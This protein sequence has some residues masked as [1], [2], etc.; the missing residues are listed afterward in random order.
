MDQNLRVRS[1]SDLI[2]HHYLRS[3]LL[4]VL[5]VE[6]VLVVAYFAVN[7]WSNAESEKTL[8]AE[9][10][11]I[12]PHLA[13][14]EASLLQEGFLRIDRETSL[15]AREHEALVADPGRFIVRGEKPELARAANGS[16]YQTN[17]TEHSGYFASAKTVMD[18]AERNLAEATASLD[19]LYEHAVKDIPNV[20]ASYYNSADNTNRLYPYIPKVWEQ[21]PAELRMADFNFYYL[22]DPSH[23]PL[24]KT[25]WTGAYLDPA[26]Q[27]WMVSCISPVYRRDTLQGVVGLDVTID[28]IVRNLFDQNLPW[29]SAA[30][31]VDDSGMIIAMSSPVE[32]LLGLR[33]LKA[34]VYDAAISTE[35]LKPREFNL[36]SNPDRGIAER[37]RRIIDSGEASTTIRIGG[38]ESF[39][40][41]ERIP[42]TGWRLFLVAQSKDVFQSV[43]GVSHRSRTVGWF[44]VGG[45]LA[46]YIG[47]F[48]YL[49][50]N[51]RR[52]SEGISRPITDLAEATTRLGKGASEVTEDLGP[53]GIPEIDRLTEN[54]NA[55]SHNLDQRSQ[56]LVDARVRE[57]LSS[58]EAELSFARGQFE[59]ASAYLHNVGNLAVRLGT[60]A[61]DLEEIVATTDQY[62]EVF[63]RVR[64]PDGGP[65]LDKFEDV[66]VGKVVPKLRTCSQDLSEVR[67]NIHKAIEHQQRSFLEG[68]EQLA[69]EEFDLSESVER[70]CREFGT[71]AHG[72]RIGIRTAIEP[73][74]VVRNH[75]H[76][77]KAGIVNAIKNAYESIGPAEG[78]IEVAV[79]RDPG[80]GRA[81]VTV[82]DNG[83][84]I[85]DADRPRILTAGFTTKP[86]G[87]GL[88]LHSLAVF[89]A[90]HNGAVVLESPGKG[91]GATLK[92]EVG[93]A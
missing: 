8:R 74:L 1:L 34:H 6:L 19:P 50:R 33:E 64:L 72:N 13:R 22:A 83:Q 68:G 89:L 93:D 53:S 63:R 25:V 36:M 81:V 84:G 62:P 59:T 52:M 12:L 15:L 9:V 38:K 14:Q 58:K 29:N 75:R 67:T 51:A 90:S 66:L 39:L 71:W 43:E 41:Q 42:E 65:L 4:P 70:A 79:S 16:W 60:C 47:F 35:K 31:V 27:G 49:R 3:A 45:M 54:F 21:Y 91:M 5:T 55:L 32:E 11:Q 7:A 61:M 10:S 2:L 57:E 24:R 37:F 82:S 56:E 80:S 46:F 76:Q 78:A 73:G 17:R 88:G 69:P 23:D 18:H 30:F 44:V 92:I 26:G 20:V 40:V 48:S 28:K 87:H 86:W 77:I 85:S